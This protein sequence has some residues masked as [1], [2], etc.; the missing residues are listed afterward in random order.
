MVPRRRPHLRYC[1]SLTFSIQSTFLPLRNSVTAIC[2]IAV[3]GAAPCQCFSPGR[4]PDDI[5]RTDFFDWPAFG[6]RPA[7][8]G[9]DDE[10]LAER[11]GVPRGTGA[12]L[13]GDVTA[14]HTRWVANLEHRVHADGAGKIGFGSFAGRPRSVA[15]DIHCL[16]PLCLRHRR[17]AM[18]GR[19]NR[20]ASHAARGAEQTPARELAA[21]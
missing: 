9:R 5:A 16:S 11:M 19:S 13:E 10:G 20:S 1:S 8:A 6:L 21:D 18:A 12:R 3:V 14:A 2:V 17:C 4:K 15:F 7:K